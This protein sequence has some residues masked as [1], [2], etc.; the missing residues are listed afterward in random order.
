MLATLFKR[1]TRSVGDVDSSPATVH[2]LP[3]E[4][5]G[6]PLARSGAVQ[7]VQ[8]AHVRLPAAQREL[9]WKAETLERLARAYWAYVTKLFLNLV[10]MDY[11]PDSTSVVFL[12]K[13]LP[14]LRFGAPEY[15]TTDDGSG[16]SVTWPVERGIL[17]AKEGRNR[18]QLLIRVH[19]IPEDDVECDTVEVRVAVR[20]FYPWLRG[21][22]HFSRFGTWLYAR[23]QLAMHVIVCNGFL[24]SLAALELPEPPEATD[25]EST[26]ERD[27]A[28]VGTAA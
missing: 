13:R 9:L 1:R 4:D 19:Q 5:E 25:S 26:P 20:N 22:G 14:L 6:E 8:E 24:R 2:I 27:P 17:V 16:G 23:T 15:E 18:G 12:S 11:A 21:H 28:R 7:S 10:R 3:A